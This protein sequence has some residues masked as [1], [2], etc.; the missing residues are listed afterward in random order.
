MEDNKEPIKVTSWDEVENPKKVTTWE[1]TETSPESGAKKKYT[2]LIGK[3]FYIEIGFI[4][5]HF[6]FR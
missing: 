6:G 2:R 4:F 3:H 5:I 1:E